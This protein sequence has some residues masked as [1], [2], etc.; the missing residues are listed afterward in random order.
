MWE[1]CVSKGRSRTLLVFGALLVAMTGSF[2][3]QVMS[4][5]DR[6]QEKND[7]LRFLGGC[8]S[9]NNSFVTV[10][11]APVRKLRQDEQPQCGTW[12]Y[13][14]TGQQYTGNKFDLTS[15]NR[16]HFVS[17]LRHPTSEDLPKYL[18]HV[19]S[20]PSPFHTITT[21]R[22]TGFIARH[23]RFKDNESLWENGDYDD[24]LMRSSVTKNS[25]SFPVYL[26]KNGMN[27]RSL[28]RISKIWQKTFGSRAMDILVIN[29]YTAYSSGYTHTFIYQDT[30]G[31]SKSIGGC[32]DRRNSSRYVQL[33]GTAF[34]FVLDDKGNCL[35]GTMLELVP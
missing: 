22:I 17:T 32:G 27:E 11:F 9:G 3:G 10:T 6:N 18:W 7:A 4:G 5:Q 24:F 1:R 33:P 16:I 35:A 21:G 23:E 30:P 34:G 31:N 2:Q 29:S 8:K 26:R 15:G 14:Y 13:T 12:R 25:G 20:V 19:I 28:N